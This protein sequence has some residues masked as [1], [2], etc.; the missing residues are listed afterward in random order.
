MELFHR[1]QAFLLAVGLV[2]TCLVYTADGCSSNVDCPHDQC[3]GS[4]RPDVLG[5]FQSCQAYSQ[6][7][8]GCHGS[9]YY[10]S[11]DCMPGLVCEE[12]TGVL[13]HLHTSKG[14][15]RKQTDPS[16]IIG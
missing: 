8:E 2:C 9:L 11:C 14:I 16:L 7:G 12:Y 13:S 4:A 5:L 10:N 1:I 15:C 6:E 3:C